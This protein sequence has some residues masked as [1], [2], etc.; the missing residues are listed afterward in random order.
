[1]ALASGR[2]IADLYGH[3]LRGPVQHGLAVEKPTIIDILAGDPVLRG[4]RRRPPFR[5]ARP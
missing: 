3:F 1:M 2:R 5:N 4:K